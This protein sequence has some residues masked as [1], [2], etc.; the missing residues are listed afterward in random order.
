METIQLIL[1]YLNGKASQDDREAMETWIS[2]S[3]GNKSLFEDIKSIDE[4]S[5]NLNN[6][7]LI[8]TDA[9]WSKFLNKVNTSQ[10]C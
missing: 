2:K 9:E 4:Q 7:I 10:S 6:T 1:Q 8:D 5:N 3:E